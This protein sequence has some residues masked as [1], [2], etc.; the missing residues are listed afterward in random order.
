MTLSLA[1]LMRDLPHTPVFTRFVF[2]DY[3]S[4]S[5]QRKQRVIYAP[6][7]AMEIVHKRIGYY[8]AE[9][10][11]PLPHAT[12]AVRGQSTLTNIRRHKGNR[13]FLLYDIRDAYPSVDLETLIRLLAE[14]DPRIASA[15]RYSETE[16]V[17]RRFV[18]AP[19]G[20]LMTGAPSSPAFF[21]LYAGMLIDRPLGE[22]AAWH[23][24]TY[25]RYLDDITLSSPEPFG[26]RVNGKRRHR[27]VRD[28]I[29]RI[30]QS[31]GM[32]IHDTKAKAHDTRCGAVFV[33]GLGMDSAGRIFVP[34]HFFRRVRGAL[35]TAI[36]TAGVYPTPQT[37]NGLMGVVRAVTKRRIFANRTEQKLLDLHTKW[38]W[39][40][41][42][43][44]LVSKIRR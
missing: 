43:L 30:I 24:I 12:G 42:H 23:G 17:L 7:P 26:H 6:N 40:Q 33:N 37:I 39:Q 2:D 11:P 28:G 44:K 31:S 16:E 34:R 10:M 18:M 41:K 22:Y 21:N 25:T 4:I 14:R 35:R 38:K 36:K 13:F 27:K 8:L 3:N 1:M 5:G 20:G 9:R 15:D 29:R 19:E 32:A